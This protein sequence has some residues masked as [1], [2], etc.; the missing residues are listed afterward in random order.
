MLSYVQEYVEKMLNRG[1]YRNK[2]VTSALQ[3]F[4]TGAKE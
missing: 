4:N 3:K 2:F 1:Y